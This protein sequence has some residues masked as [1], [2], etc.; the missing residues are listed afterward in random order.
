MDM[1]GR[2]GPHLGSLSRG[3]RGL[4]NPVESFDHPVVA[5]FVGQTRSH[6]QSDSATS[7]ALSVYGSDE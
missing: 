5:N 1:T 2:N 7:S 6:R 4:E 3:G